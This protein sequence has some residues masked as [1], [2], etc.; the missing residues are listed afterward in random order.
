M[1]RSPASIAEQDDARSTPRWGDDGSQPSDWQS[2][3][4]LSLSAARQQTE[5]MRL[6]RRGFIALAALSGGSVVVFALAHSL[7]QGF[8]RTPTIQAEENIQLVAPRFMGRDDA[9]QEFVITAD[10][11]ERGAEQDAP[12]TLTN[13][14]FENAKKQSI[15]APAGLY[16]STKQRLE[17][18]DGFTFQQGDYVFSGPTATVDTGGALVSGAEGVEGYGPLG[19]VRADAYE[20]YFREGRVF[21][22]GDVRGVLQSK[23]VSRPS[24]GADAP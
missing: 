19:S 22:R 11:A 16:E 8:M 17:L 21:L 6:A 2:D 20:F 3:R 10:K 12:V 23:G 18:R 24:Q 9:G 1:S 4:S 15:Q 5:R 13:P 14:R 7:S